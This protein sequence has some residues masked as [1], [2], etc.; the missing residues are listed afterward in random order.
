MNTDTGK[1]QD[2]STGNSSSTPPTKTLAKENA[3]EGEGKSLAPAQ[4]NPVSNSSLK[5]LAGTLSLLQED[6][7]QLQKTLAKLSQKGTKSV[8]M[9]IS[10]EGGVIVYVQPIEDHTFSIE[11]GHILLDG[12]PVTGWEPPVPDTGKKK[13]HFI[14]I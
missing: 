5:T 4:T 12:A 3:S 1:K 13:A 14:C 9:Q 6:C 7:A 8:R 11:D 2:T 10:D